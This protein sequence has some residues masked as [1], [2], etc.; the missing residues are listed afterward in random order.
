MNVETSYYGVSLPCGIFTWPVGTHG[1]CVQNQSCICRMFGFNFVCI[2]DARAVRPY[3]SSGTSFVYLGALL[4]YLYLV[5]LYLVYLYLVYLYL[6][7]LLLTSYVFRTHGP[8]VPTF[9][10]GL[11]S[12][13]SVTFLSTCTSLTCLLKKWEKVRK[14]VALERFAFRW[15]MYYLCIR[16]WRWSCKGLFPLFFCDFAP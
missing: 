4:V 9:Q 12:F 6:V 10:V 3:I 2:S 16:K 7:Y 14:L 11:R 5:Y 13:I 8:C 15:K 1:A